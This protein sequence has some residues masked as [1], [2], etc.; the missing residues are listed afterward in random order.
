MTKLSSALKTAASVGAGLSLAGC[1][2]TLPTQPQSDAAPTPLRQTQATPPAAKAGITW[3]V[4]ACNKDM[5]VGSVTTA[6]TGNNGGCL[7][8]VVSGERETAVPATRAGARITTN[9]AKETQGSKQAA[10]TVT[11]AP[12]GK[13]PD[14]T[15]YAGKLT[16]SECSAKTST[17][18]NTVAG[19]GAS[20]LDFGKNVLGAAAG[21]K[22]A[23][24][25]Q[26]AT[27]GSVFSN[28]AA[29]GARDAATAGTAAATSRGRDAA[30]TAA[31]PLTTA[32]QACNDQVKALS[33]ANTAKSDFKSVVTALATNFRAT[34]PGY[35]PVITVTSELSA[36]QNQFF[37]DVANTA[38]A[39]ASAPA[40]ARK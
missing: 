10:T 17:A 14:A 36:A 39:A 28:V 21:N 32:Q 5:T 24:V 40:P 31:A 23:Q 26:G 29:K 3:D 27:N 34:N 18:V 22:A 2:Q 15:P 30:A 25:T 37:Q 38:T 9:R 35:K 7:R 4:E 13:A 33:E 8:V 1:L 6:F 12:V 20:A 11:A 19:W 16:L